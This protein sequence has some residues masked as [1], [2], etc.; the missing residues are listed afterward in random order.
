MRVPNNIIA[1]RKSAAIRGLYFVALVSWFCSL[2]SICGARIIFVPLYSLA[3]YR[4]GWVAMQ[5]T[6][7]EMLGNC[8]VEFAKVGAD[9]WGEFSGFGKAEGF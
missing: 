9:P 1:S 6:F 5:L 7:S 4:I 2:V 8:V 3:Q